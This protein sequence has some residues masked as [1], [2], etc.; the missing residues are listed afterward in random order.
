M[1]SEAVTIE[2]PTKI[3]ASLTPKQKAEWRQTGALPEAPKETPP[4]EATEA[5]SSPAAKE[6][7]EPV[8]AEASAASAPAVKEE[9]KPKGAEARIKELLADNKRLE[10]EL[11]ELR[12]RPIAAPAKIE[13]V[14]KPRRGEVD[15]KTG[16]A[17]YA[18]DEA[19]EEALDKYLS[20]K[21]KAESRREFEESQRQARIAEQNRITEKRWQNSLKIATEQHPDFAQVLDIGDEGDRKGVFRNKDLKTIKTNGVLDAWILDSEYGAVMLYHLAKNPSEI[22]RIQSLA[23]FHA[24]RELTKLEDKLASGSV[25]TPKESPKESSSSPTETRRV[26]SAPAPAASVS[27][28]ATAPVDEVEAAVKSEDFGRYA[29]AANAEEAARRKKS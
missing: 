25:T 7:P 21:I 28:R 8:K 29:R 19:F 15:P 2:S 22:E 4:K 13:E 12:K 24:A 27:G 16:Q 9:P 11:D 14:A 5:A 1:A 26:S 10:S 23:P 6:S 18:T 17:L 3:L 20:T